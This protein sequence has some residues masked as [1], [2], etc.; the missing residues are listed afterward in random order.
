MAIGPGAAAD[1]FITAVTGQGQEPGM[2]ICVVVGLAAGAVM[3]GT[4][5]IGDSRVP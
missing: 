4:E 5:G 1:M 3:R 2:F